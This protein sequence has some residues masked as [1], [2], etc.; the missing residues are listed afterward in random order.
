MAIIFRRAA[1][2]PLE[3]LDATAPDGAVIGIIGEDGA[4]KGALLRLAAGLQKPVSGSVEASA[5]RRMLGPGDELDFSPVSVLALEHTFARHDAVV[6]QRA[7]LALDCLRRSGVTA[8]LVSHENDLLHDFCDEIWWLDRGKLAGRGDPE[9]MLRAYAAH[10]SRR[11]RAW[12]ESQKASVSPRMRRGDG[13][14]EITGLELLGEL[15]GPPSR[16]A[17]VNCVSRA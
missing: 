11:V 15:G 2:P 12:A 16:P 17:A 9:E 8:L 4:G 1:C 7:L 14:A 6:R 10:V 3:P 13:R 5:K